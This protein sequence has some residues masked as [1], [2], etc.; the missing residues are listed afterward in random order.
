MVGCNKCSKRHTPLGYNLTTGKYNVVDEQ[1]TTEQVDLL[2]DTL[3]TPQT[4]I[5]KGERSVIAKEAPPSTDVS[6]RKITEEII[7]VQ[8][9]FIVRLKYGITQ[10][11]GI[12]DLVPCNSSFYTAITD[13]DNSAF[14][15]GGVCARFCATIEYLNPPPVNIEYVFFKTED[16]TPCANYPEPGTIASA[17]LTTGFFGGGIYG[18]SPLGGLIE[19]SFPTPKPARY[20]YDINISGQSRNIYFGLCYF[21][22][23]PFG[24]LERYADSANFIFLGLPLSF[25]V[26]QC[27]GDA[28]Q[29]SSNWYTAKA[30]Q[31]ASNAP[32][33]LFRNLFFTEWAIADW[34]YSK[35]LAGNDADNF[36]YALP[37]G[38]IESPCG[39]DPVTRTV[40]FGA[41]LTSGEPAWQPGLSGDL[42][43]FN[44][45]RHGSHRFFG[46]Q[47]WKLERLP[48]SETSF[49]FNEEFLPNE[50]V[51]QYVLLYPEESEGITWKAIELIKMK[52]IEHDFDLTVDKENIG[53]CVSDQQGKI[54]A[55]IAH[56]YY[57]PPEIDIGTQLNSSFVTVNLNNLDITTSYFISRD[58]GGE[59]L[60]INPVDNYAFDAYILPGE[61]FPTTVT[62]CQINL[63][64]T[65]TITNAGRTF[66]LEE[67]NSNIGLNLGQLLIGNLPVT[68]KLYEG[69][70][71][72]LEDGTC[73]I[74]G[75]NVT[76]NA[77]VTQ[78]TRQAIQSVMLADKSIDDL[79]EVEVLRVKP[80]I[81]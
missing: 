72:L 76:E 42:Q 10:E 41:I 71:N 5:V 78:G 67:S 77:L 25:C 14:S 44:W 2:S 58:N 3:L 18:Q 64:H 29:F 62:P 8:A 7:P 68:W 57:E 39:A 51:H 40:S 65:H 50:V 70:A 30:F 56:G 19:R 4:R 16:L 74:L 9:C 46:S 27:S 55:S 75:E 52:G 15:I 32:T 21:G 80:I 79:L 53:L 49:W 66:R 38:K 6:R 37:I 11:E 61:S 43:V 34:S 24:L 28:V 59:A 17:Q 48:Y 73:Q 63:R 69:T 81:R 20:T 45:G 54:Y 22:T 12:N 31:V 13:T 23:T 60:P 36:R 47:T 35:Y 26:P 33:G 1:G